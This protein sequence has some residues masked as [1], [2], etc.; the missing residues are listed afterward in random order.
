MKMT[1][2]ESLRGWRERLRHPASSPGPRARRGLAPRWEAP[3]ISVPASVRMV[4]KKGSPILSLSIP[5]LSL[6]P[7]QAIPP[8]T[9]SEE[10][11]SSSLPH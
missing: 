6:A 9:V 4:W 7:N 3:G 1:Q 2:Q 8:L 10:S 5:K 11:G